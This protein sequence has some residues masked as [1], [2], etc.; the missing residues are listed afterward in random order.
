M[1]GTGPRT[2]VQQSANGTLDV[3]GTDLNLQGENFRGTFGASRPQTQAL[4]NLSPRTGSAFGTPFRSPDFNP[5]LPTGSAPAATEIDA[6]AYR[7]L[8]LPRFRG[9]LVAEGRP[10]TADRAAADG[11]RYRFFQGRWWYWQAGGN[12]LYWDGGRWQAFAGGK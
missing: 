11:R 10:A 5:S 12:W 9:S 8:I 1:Q 4:P 7:N 3:G 2:E 6:G